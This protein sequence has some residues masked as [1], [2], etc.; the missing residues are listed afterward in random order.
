MLIVFRSNWIV[1][2]LHHFRVGC[3]IC[4]D[5]EHVQTAAVPRLGVVDAPRHRWVVLHFIS[6]ARVQSDEGAHRFRLVPD[7]P[8]DVT[9][10]STPREFGTGSHHSPPA[11]SGVNWMMEPCCSHSPASRNAAIPPYQ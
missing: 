2:C 6:R 10:L 11:R 3:A 4:K 9:V 8:E 7:T 1:L 5:V